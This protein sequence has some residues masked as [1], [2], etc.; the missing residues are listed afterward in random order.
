MVEFIS[1]E[2]E[3]EEAE[4]PDEP[5]VPEPEATLESLVEE[6]TEELGEP[7]QESQDYQ[8]EPAEEKGEYAQP[9]EALGEAH[10]LKEELKPLVYDDNEIPVVR[11]VFAKYDKKDGKWWLDKVTVGLVK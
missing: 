8:D 3:I 4:T 1:P 6:Q 9:T 11:D 7:E 5:D 2:T 10:A